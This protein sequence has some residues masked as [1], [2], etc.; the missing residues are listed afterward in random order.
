MKKSPKITTIRKLVTAFPV[1][2]VLV[3][4]EIL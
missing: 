3:I 1:G 4:T 2:F